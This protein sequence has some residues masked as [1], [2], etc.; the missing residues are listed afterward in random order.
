MSFADT[1]NTFGDVIS[2]VTG[3][4]EGEA[5]DG[6]ASTDGLLSGLRTTP[7]VR[8]RSRSR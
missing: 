8:S 1:E 2:R 5:T 7:A 3:S 6:V 4:G